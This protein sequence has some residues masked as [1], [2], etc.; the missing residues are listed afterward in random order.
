VFLSLFPP[1]V[2]VLPRITG[3][4]PESTVENRRHRMFTGCVTAGNH[5]ESIFRPLQVESAH[6]LFVHACMTAEK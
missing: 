3:N 2:A 4:I 1:A 6:Q 5:F